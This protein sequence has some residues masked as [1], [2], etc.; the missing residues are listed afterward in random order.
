MDNKNK[1]LQISLKEIA[2]NYCS[3]EFHFSDTDSNCPWIKKIFETFPGCKAIERKTLPR[4]IVSVTVKSI[5][6][7]TPSIWSKAISIKDANARFKA[8]AEI[9]KISKPG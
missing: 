8:Y 6:I 3:S 9:R 4:R 1:H 2:K 7:P 5:D